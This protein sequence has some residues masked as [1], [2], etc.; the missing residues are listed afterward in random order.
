[1]LGVA[2]VNC[3]AIEDSTVGVKAALDAG[4]HVIGFDK[5]T[6]QDFKGADFVI[7]TLTALDVGNI[8]HI[9]EP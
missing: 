8:N 9:G 3:V 5:G 6:E 1:M 7:R 4:M 2:P